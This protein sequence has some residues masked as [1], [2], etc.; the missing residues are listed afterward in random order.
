MCGGFHRRNDWRNGAGIC[1]SLSL[2]FAL[3]KLH[4]STVS[5][6]S[7]RRLKNILD[8]LIERNYIKEMRG[9]INGK[10]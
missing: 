9:D 1:G 6:S 5:R 7:A 4:I 8:I 10:I 3:G 2:A